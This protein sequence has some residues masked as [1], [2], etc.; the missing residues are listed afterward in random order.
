MPVVDG[1]IRYLLESRPEWS[2]VLVGPVFPDSQR[3]IFSWPKYENLYLLGKKEY[4]KLPSYLSAFDVCIAPYL[5]NQ[6]LSYVSAPLKIYEYLAA[7]KPIVATG[8]SPAPFLVDWVQTAT[9]PDEFVIHIENCLKR[10]NEALAKQ[11]IEVS[12]QNTWDKRVN[13]VL[14][15][16]TAY[17]N[18]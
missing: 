8:F 12:R 18:R 11:R 10:N 14:E 17:L 1:L 6:Q 13:Q 5:D 3:V 7:G 4:R 2:V 16:M 9:S 15:L